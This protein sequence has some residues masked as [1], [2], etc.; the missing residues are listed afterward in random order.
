VLDANP[1]ENLEKSLTK[2]FTIVR[3]AETCEAKKSSLIFPLRWRCL[4]NPMASNRKVA[5]SVAG[6][7]CIAC[8]IDLADDRWALKKL[9]R[10]NQ[11]LKES[12]YI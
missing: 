9:R 3:I 7:P 12:P 5:V 6:L 1:F 11:Y 4:L 2:P 10:L 8:Q